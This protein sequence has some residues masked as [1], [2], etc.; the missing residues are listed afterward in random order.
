MKNQAILFC[1]LGYNLAAQ[2][3]PAVYKQHVRIADSLYTQKSYLASAK[4]YSKAFES[5]G[6]KGYQEDRYNAACSWAM[7]GKP[8]SSFFNL[9]RLAEKPSY[10]ALSR[11]KIDPDLEGLHSDKRWPELLKK[12]KSNKDLAEADLNRPV[13]AI[14]DSIYELDQKGRFVVDQLMKEHGNDSKEV[15]AYWK[16]ISKQDS[17]NLITVS[18]LIDQYGWLGPQEIGRQGNSTLFLVIQHA[19]QEMQEKYIPLLR[20]A[21]ANKKAYASDLALME[22]RLALRQGR[23]QIYGSQIGQGTNGTA[24][25][26]YPLEDPDHVDERRKSVGLVPLQ[27]YVNNWNIIWN[28]EQYKIDLPKLEENIKTLGW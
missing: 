3:I 15:Q 27:D 20:E 24:F 25:F 5:I 18:K 16:N 11:I 21:V 7:A 13:I 14:L 26:I 19:P 17:F 12:I 23:K 1:F 22:D 8:D 9:F 4:E 6:W 2:S 28:V 10:T